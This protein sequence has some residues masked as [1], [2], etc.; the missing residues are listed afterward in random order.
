MSQG[1]TGAPVTVQL[2]HVVEGRLTL[3]S[4]TP[5]TTA[6]VTG[7]GTLYFTNFR[8]N[9]VRVYNGTNWIVKTFSEISLALTITANTFYYV[10]LD[11]DAATLS[12]STTGSANT[13]GVPLKS[14]DNTKLLVGYIYASGTNT[15]EDSKANRY[16]CNLYN[17]S[18]RPIKLNPG[19]SDGNSAS[20]ITVSSTTFTSLNGGTGDLAGFIRHPAHPAGPFIYYALADGGAGGTA[21]AAIGIDSTTEAYTAG[22]SPVAG[23]LTTAMAWCEGNTPG[24]LSVGKH[25]VYML[26]A[27]ATSNATFYTDIARNGSTADPPGTML[28]GHVWG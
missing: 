27:R 22:V 2:A 20:T 11:D 5:I 4:G 24:P 21:Y 8:G 12:V 10:Y 18:P 16:V 25:T 23:R 6:D 3:T 19:Y 17:S 13:D 26:A 28:I 9:R 14:D 7:A 1:L 15:T